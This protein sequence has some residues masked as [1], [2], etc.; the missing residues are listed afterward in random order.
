[1]PTSE[2]LET[3]GAR[4]DRGK[5]GLLHRFLQ[6]AVAGMAQQMGYTVQ[7][8]SPSPEGD[9]QVDLVLEKGGERVGVELSVSTKPEY[10]VG[11]LDRNWEGFS[12]V[13]LAFLDPSAL[14]QAQEALAGQA[15]GGR[16]FERV[17]CLV[18]DVE[19]RLKARSARSGESA[20]STDVS[21]VPPQKI[22]GPEPEQKGP[23][24]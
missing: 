23:L 4:F 11:K 6:E 1:M 24:P 15:S 10:E 17:L 2:G 3:L 22:E 14:R 19:E 18:S 20:C 9:G 13:I 5:G 16:G 8:E 7:M 12:R 21:S